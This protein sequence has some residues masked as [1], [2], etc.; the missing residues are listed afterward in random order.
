MLSE[1]AWC[2]RGEASETSVSSL[3]DANTLL[4]V[5]QI[6][7]KAVAAT[8]LPFHTDRQTKETCIFAAEQYVRALD[9][10]SGAGLD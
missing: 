5:L 10:V 8:A 6:N 3:V 4:F 1:Y 2:R 7:D 9:V